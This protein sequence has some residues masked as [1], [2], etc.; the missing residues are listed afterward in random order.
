MIPF[1]SLNERLCDRLVVSCDL[2]QEDRDELDE[3]EGD[4]E[5]SIFFILVGDSSCC[6]DPLLDNGD[7]D[8]E[9]DVD[10]SIAPCC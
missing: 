6:S 7:V 8:T 3:A 5:L 9:L 4:G 10:K 1:A 2:E